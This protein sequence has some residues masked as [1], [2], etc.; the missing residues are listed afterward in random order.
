MATH[1]ELRAL[2][3][4]YR[5]RVRRDADAHLAMADRVGEAGEQRRRERREME[6]RITDLEA[7]N[8]DLRSELRNKNE[9]LDR[10]MNTKTFRYTA[11][12]RRFYGHLR[13]GR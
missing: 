12:V 9:E 10:L 2:R 6:A 13:G 8:T 4:A 7:Q 11:A 3:Q 5:E 1:D